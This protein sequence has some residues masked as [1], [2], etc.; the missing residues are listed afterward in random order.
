MDAITPRIKYIKIEKRAK[1]NSPIESCDDF[2]IDL[3]I[4]NMY[5]EI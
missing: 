3:M 1:Q 2:H 5:I 4:L